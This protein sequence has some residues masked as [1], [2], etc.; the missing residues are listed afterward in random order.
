MLLAGS[1]SSD[2]QL[3]HLLGPAGASSGTGSFAFSDPQLHVPR[4]AGAR[5]PSRSRAFS[6]LAPH[7]FPGFCALQAAASRSGSPQSQP[8]SLPPPRG[9]R[10]A[11]RP[12]WLQVRIHSPRVRRGRPSRCQLLRLGLRVT[13]LSKVTPWLGKLTP[14]D[15]E[16][17]GKRACHC[18]EAGEL[19]C[20]IFTLE[21]LGLHR[22]STLL[23]PPSASSCS[24]R[25]C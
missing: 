10:G 3:P 1:R 21:L 25:R 20:S 16:A 9:R 11:G 23:L 14:R 24:F 2:S 15:Q 17:Q 6:D 5:S 18:G 7:A 4:P 22:S 8:G 12:A 19:R 13:L